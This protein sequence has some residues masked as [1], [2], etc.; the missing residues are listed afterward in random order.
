VPDSARRHGVWP[1]SEVAAALIA[2]FFGLVVAAFG[3][4][5]GVGWK[6]KKDLSAQYDADLRGLRLKSYLSLWAATELFALYARESAQ[7]FPN[8]RELREMTLE[9]REWYF[10]VGGIYLSEPARDSYFDVQ[11]ALGIVV[12]SIRW[13]DES[14]PCLDGRTFEQIRV[15]T[16]TLRTRLT[17]DVGTRKPFSFDPNMDASA[18]MKPV[19]P[20][21][22][23]E[24][25][26]TVVLTA[27]RDAWPGP[28]AGVLA[29]PD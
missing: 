11:K 5:V 4:Y 6:I 17:H 10:G 20:A 18:D 13:R 1:L 19:P 21:E 28:T 27:L 26:P 23:T 12:E 14:L 22:T 7:A 16:S 2:G 8:R 15:L 25:S 24:P 3:T 9:L 29:G